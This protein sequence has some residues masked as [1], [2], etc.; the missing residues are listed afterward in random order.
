METRDHILWGCTYAKDVW[1][2]LSTQMSIQL[3]QAENICDAWLIRRGIPGQT[4]RRKWDAIWA[5]AA[6]ALW[7]ERN[8]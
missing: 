5:V 8:R 4:T 2:A 7:K 3:P 6:W 1:Q